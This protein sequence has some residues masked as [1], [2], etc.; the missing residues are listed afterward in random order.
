MPESDFDWND[1]YAIP[2]GLRFRPVPSGGLQV[3]NWGGDLSVEIPRDWIS[4]YLV[5][6]RSQTAE[7]AYETAAE[8][9]EEVDREVLRE[10]L[11]SW[12]G[13]GLLQAVET[14][15]PVPSRLALFTKSAEAGAARVPLRSHFELQ[16]PVEL[17]PGLETREIHD[18]GRFPWVA[19]LEASFP[20]IREEFDRLA[21]AGGQGTGPGF[22]PVY[23]GQT[24]TGEWA[25]SFLWIFGKQ[26]E[27]TCRLCPET[28]RLLSAIPGVAEFGTTLYSALAPH[29]QIAPHYGYSN[30]KLRCQLPIRVPGRCKLKV[31]EHEIEQREGKCIVFDDSFLHSAWNDSDEARFVLVFDF[32]HPDL[33]PEEIRYLARLAQERELAKTY[34]AQGGERVAWVA[35][36]AH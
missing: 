19:G 11:Q 7:T 26:V 21:G 20:V 22:S 28:T 2:A 8:E 35:D 14:S 1:S 12:L 13:R 29:T 27:E 24:S 15:A 6:A 25:A 33:T 17:Y 31:G 10:L 23:R 3:D 4:L 32:Y 9:W 30:A 34:Q 16:R 18:P 5:F 36:P